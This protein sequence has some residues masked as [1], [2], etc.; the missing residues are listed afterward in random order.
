MSNFAPAVDNAIKL[1]EKLADE[2]EPVGVS[3]LS[4]KLGINKNMVFRILNSLE[5]SGWVHCSNQPDKKYQL[6]LRPFNV[7]SKALCTMSLSSVATPLVYDLWKQTGECTYL[8]IKSGDKLTYIQHL[9]G[10]G[11]VRVAGTV[12]GTYELYCSAPGKIILAYSDEAFIGEYTSRRHKK[13]TKNTITT[14]KELLSELE[15]VRSQ[16]YA[17]DNEEFGNGIVCVSAPIFDYTGS[18]VGAVG[19]SVSTVTHTFES[20]MDDIKPLVIDTAAK[21]SLSLGYTK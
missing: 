7:T 15:K 9:D 3:E 8:A 14:K 10:T 17:T 13:N 21:I 18:L 2:K 19:C 1:I 12:G 6:S 20:V 11:N 4:R 16:G 5:A